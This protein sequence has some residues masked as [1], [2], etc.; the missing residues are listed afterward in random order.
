MRTTFSTLLVALL[1]WASTGTDAQ[2]LYTCN[3]NGRTYQSSQ[4][5]GAV[6]V[7]GPVTNQPTYEP[8]L[9]R[10]GQAPKHLLYMSPRCASLND[11]IRTAPARGLK[12]DT[13]S[14]MQREYSQE[15][16]DNE[17]E[18]RT[19]LSQDRDDQKRQATEANN[20]AK[21]EKE[22]A[23]MREQQCGES[24]RIL[25]AKR[26]RTDLTEGEKADLRRSEETYRSRCT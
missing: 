9:A 8:P 22:R 18:A 16:S 3:R 10:S 15:C 23:S 12:Y 19:R 2:T 25:Y 6:G 21:L 24:K 11:A 20:N 7:Y 5:C 26:A 13:I 14:Q 17:S 1:V 4:A